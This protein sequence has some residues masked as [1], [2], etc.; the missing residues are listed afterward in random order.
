MSKSPAG[1]GDLSS[2]LLN[3]N[4]GVNTNVTES[5]LLLLAARQAKP[6]KRPVVGARNNDFIQNASKLRR[7]WA[8]VPK[9]H[10]T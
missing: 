10:L 8:C 5:K 9:E 4:N 3:N 1:Q 2:Y 7:W 6:V